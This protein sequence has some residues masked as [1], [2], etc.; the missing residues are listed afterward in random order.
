M[1]GAQN[2][3]LNACMFSAKNAHAPVHARL[4]NG[5]ELFLPWKLLRTYLESCASSIPYVC[6]HVYEC[7]TESVY[8]RKRDRVCVVYHIWIIFAPAVLLNQ[9]PE[10][11]RYVHV[12]VYMLYVCVCMSTWYIGVPCVMLATFV[13]RRPGLCGIT[14][15]NPKSINLMWPLKV[16]HR[17]FANS[18]ASGGMF[19][20]WL[21]DIMKTM[22]EWGE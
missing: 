18:G 20:E 16:L 8:V 15:D 2:T 10:L 6:W 21:N 14:R 7:V 11:M 3:C 5:T 17:M 1:H 12:C 19:S 9:I 22:S 13:M 4:C